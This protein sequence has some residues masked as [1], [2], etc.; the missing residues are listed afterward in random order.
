[1]NK[2]LLS[3]VTIL[4][5][6]IVNTFPCTNLIVGKKAST[7][8]S[9][10]VSYSADSGAKY[11]WLRHYPAQKHEPGSTVEIYDWNS[12]APL[13]KIEQVAETYNVIGNMNE[14]Q[15]T[16]GETTFG[17]RQD[18]TNP[19]GIVDYAALMY[20]P[21]QR[22]KT[23]REAIEVID[24]LV[25]K[26]GYRSSGESFSIADPN[27]AWILEIVG[28]GKGVKGAVWVAVRIPDDCIA[29]HANQSRIH[30]F[31]LKDKKN[32]L[33]SPDVISF[34]REKGYFSGKDEDFSFADAY[35]PIDFGLRRFCEARVWSFFNR[36]NKD[37]H[38]YLDY[39]KGTSKTPMPLYIKPDKKLSVGDVKNMMR[40]HFEGTE[41][42]PTQDVGAGPFNSP[43]RFNG[44]NYSVDG[45]KYFNERP[46]ST[47]QTYMSFVA[48]MRA[49]KPN[50]IGG[51]L[52]FGLD[53]ANMTVYTPIYCCT[54]KV[55]TCYSEKVCDFVTFS[56]DSSYWM[57]NWVAN[58]VYGRYSMMIDDVR[59]VQKE[60][61]NS[62]ETNQEAIESTAARLYK[63]NP[64]KATEYLTS[65]SNSMAQMAHAAWRQ[66]G[67][68]LIVKYNDYSIKQEVDG[69]FQYDQYGRPLRAKRAD[70]PI[71]YLRGIVKSTGD[72]YKVTE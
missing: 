39:V 14:Y 19:S 40:D 23:A 71:E 31:N 28:K 4:I 33:Y 24:E 16:I 50:A 8:G 38:S 17:G 69:V 46:I 37:A 60:L 70:Y 58:M 5:A 6:S 2:R 56:W 59:K 48:Q 55:P 42:D 20:I 52:W 53:D 21:L 32:C 54:T 1:M 45:Q 22:S 13:G 67:E 29:A 44:L 10:I 7:D 25:Q 47:Q 61:E 11:G 26:Y 63:I 9:T 36:F 62:F 35:A 12:N 66:L 64:E 65:Y 72:R 57:H 51:V 41:L 27:E 15:V 34:A 43:Y 49:D 30:Q 3:L 18:L 68:F